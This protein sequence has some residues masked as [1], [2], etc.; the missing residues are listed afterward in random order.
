M[1]PWA[2]EI[3]GG[4]VSVG[5]YTA[6][7]ATQ[8]KR[9]RL[10]C[11]MTD[12]QSG[13]IKIGRYCLI[14]PGTRVLS[15]TSITIGDD[16]MMA[17]NVCITDADWHGLYDR[18][19]QIGSTEEV[20]IEDNVWIGDSVMVCKGVHIGENAV[21]GAGSI[22]TRDI[23]ANAIAAGNP[24]AVVKYLDAEKPIRKRSQ[25]MSDPDK[26]NKYFDMVERIR[27]EKNSLPGWI[28]ASLFPR[29]GD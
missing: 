25:W 26:L 15:A 28:R 10:T 5:D 4:P 20:T 13:K 14:C 24:A 17:Q 7:I 18:S 6:L 23:P 22:V 3:Y 27:R 16:C 12:E 2:V 11:W 8:D 19:A 21:I 1:K 9:I 29:K